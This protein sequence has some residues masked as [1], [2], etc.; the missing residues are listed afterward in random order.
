MQTCSLHGPNSYLRPQRR[1]LAKELPGGA[2]ELLQSIVG[3]GDGWRTQCCNLLD[4]RCQKLFHLGLDYRQLK[5]LQSTTISMSSGIHAC[6]LQ[7]GNT[8]V[9]D[10]YRYIQLDRVSWGIIWL[11]IWWLF[12]FPTTSSQI[13]VA[14][15]SPFQHPTSSL[16]SRRQSA[17]KLLSIAIPLFIL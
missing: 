12:S 6:C 15:K 9:D 14:I 8:M 7:A 16:S 13:H 10:I 2:K 17:T 5:D 11:F 3:R 4:G 1:I